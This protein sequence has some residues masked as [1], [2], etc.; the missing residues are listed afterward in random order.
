MGSSVPTATQNIGLTLF[1]CL[2]GDCA[3]ECAT[4]AFIPSDAGTDADAN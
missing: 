1:G 4:A 3:D 2:N